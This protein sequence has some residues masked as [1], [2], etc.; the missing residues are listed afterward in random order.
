MVGVPVNLKNFL[1]QFFTETPPHDHLCYVLRI[2]LNYRFRNY[3]ASQS[4][5]ETQNLKNNRVKAVLKKT[6][7]FPKIASFI[8]RRYQQ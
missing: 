5:I 2:L 6:A 4:Q 3:F 7:P 8:W 1:E